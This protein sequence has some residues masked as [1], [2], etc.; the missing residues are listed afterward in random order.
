ME[1]GVGGPEG[2]VA[3]SLQVD[4]GLGRGGRA[5]PVASQGTPARAL[6]DEGQ[7]GGWTAQEEAACGGW[8][9]GRRACKELT[10]GA[11]ATR[12]NLRVSL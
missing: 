1:R 2:P 10:W 11:G 9:G 8:G 6:Q 5:G 3:A 7:D 4:T 12:L